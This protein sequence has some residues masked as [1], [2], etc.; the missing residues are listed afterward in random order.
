[1]R[2]DS[3]YRDRAL[4]L[5]LPAEGRPVLSQPGSGCMARRAM[6]AAPLSWAP[7]PCLIPEKSAA[8]DTR[9]MQAT[10]PR[11]TPP[12]AA[13]SALALHDAVMVK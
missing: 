13:G 2:S 9:A 1:M 3:G 11:H 5:P 8:G 7:A 10:G 6:W 12:E 4:S